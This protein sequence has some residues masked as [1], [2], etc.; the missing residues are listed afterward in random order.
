MSLRDGVKHLLFR[1]VPLLVLSWVAMSLSQ[2]EDLSAEI[3]LAQLLT[4][5][6]VGLLSV[7][8]YRALIIFWSLSTGRDDDPDLDPRLRDGPESD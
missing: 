8:L 7:A 6:S 5:V 1:V 3:T 2:N 4:G